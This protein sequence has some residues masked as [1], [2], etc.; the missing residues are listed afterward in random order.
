VTVASVCQLDRSILG[1]WGPSVSLFLLHVLSRWGVFQNG[2]Q[3]IWLFPPSV[4]VRSYLQTCLQMFMLCS[5]KSNRIL[6]VEMCENLS[7]LLFWVLHT[8]FMRKC[9]VK[10]KQ[11]HY[12]PWGYQ[13]VEVPKIL[14][15]SAR[16]C[17]KVVSPTH[18]P[19]LPQEIFLL[20][21]SVRGWVD[22]RAI[23]RPEGLYQWKIPMTPLGI[24]PATFWFVA[25]CLN[26]CATAC[27]LENVKK[28]TT[29]RT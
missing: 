11:S 5:D 20:L 24:D 28:Q 8:P 29:F 27:L 18:R 4:Y 3:D 6:W 1:S 12:R 7:L 13:E 14:R 10:V 21:I 2:D 17:G 19:P 9:K 15:Q 23:V 22:L 25:Q 26:H 16:K